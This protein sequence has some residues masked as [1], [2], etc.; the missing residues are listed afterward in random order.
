MGAFFSMKSALAGAHA[1]PRR[2]GKG[3]IR[4]SEISAH[5][6]VRAD[7]MSRSRAFID[8]HAARS[9]RSFST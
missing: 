3:P 8:S 4:R 5:R 1:P 9:A 6:A 2:G 7:A